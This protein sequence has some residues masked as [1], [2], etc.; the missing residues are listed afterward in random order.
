MDPYARSIPLAVI[1][2]GLNAT[3]DLPEAFRDDAFL[4]YSSTRHSLHIADVDT[5]TSSLPNEPLLR[6][7]PESLSDQ[8][9]D[10]N[11]TLE[12]GTETGFPTR[13]YVQ[14]PQ[15]AFL[16]TVSAQRLPAR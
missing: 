9:N 3:L 6:R 15:T 4:P 12:D 2:P 8:P 16:N 5:E 10:Q 11:H 7:P 13:P 1:A 14:Q